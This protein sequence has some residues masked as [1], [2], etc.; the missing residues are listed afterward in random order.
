MSDKSLSP[1]QFNMW[2]SIV[3]LIYADKK[4]HPEEEAFLR[5]SIEKLSLSEPQISQLEADISSPPNLEEVF[6]KIDEPRHRSQLIYF[7]RLLFWSD[8]DF[9]AQ[10]EKILDS[11][12][13][14]VMS[15]V[16]LEAAMKRVE[17]VTQKFHQKEA[18][19]KA[20]VS[21]S[22]KLV[23]AILFWEDLY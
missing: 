1:S 17:D 11:M 20:N 14:Q 5:R 4:K 9:H 6:P 2:R 12:H 3:A 18:A 10:E 23:D 15:Q 13:A 16:D 22:Q 21:W 7:A 19:R 8:G